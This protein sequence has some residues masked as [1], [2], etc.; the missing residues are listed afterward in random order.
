MRKIKKI[1]FVLLFVVL[2]SFNCSKIRAGDDESAS[3]NV[4]VSGIPSGIS[5]SCTSPTCANT[6]GLFGSLKYKGKDVPMTGLKIILMK[7]ENGKEK[8]I[9][10]GNFFFTEAMCADFSVLFNSA[11][12]TCPIDYCLKNN[13]GE[14]KTSRNYTMSGVFMDGDQV[15]SVD[16]GTITVNYND[17]IEN[18]VNNPSV[19]ENI[20]HIFHRI[21]NDISF[22]RFL[23]PDFDYYLVFEPILVLHISYQYSDG[24]SNYYHQ[25]Y[26]GTL[27]N[28]IL[29]ML[30]TNGNGRNGVIGFDAN[31]LKYDN[32]NIINSTNSDF[33]NPGKYFNGVD[34]INFSQF[35][36]T[37]S[38]DSTKEQ[39]ESYAKF[40]WEWIKSDKINSSCKDTGNCFNDKYFDY[41]ANFYRSLG[42]LSV[43]GNAG[44]YGSDTTWHVIDNFLVN[45]YIAE[46]K[47]DYVGLSDD[48]VEN[49]SAGLSNNKYFLRAIDATRNFSSYGKG[50]ITGSKI[51][52]NV[53]S[54]NVTIKKF[55]GTSGST[56]YNKKAKFR[57]VQIDGEYVS[58]LEK[59]ASASEV[60]FENVP[61]GKYKLVEI[62]DSGN[63]DSVGQ[64]IFKIVESGV[65]KNLGIVSNIDS[66]KAESNEFNVGVGDKT[67]KVYNSETAACTT[68][69][70]NIFSTYS[71]E[72]ARG[73]NLIDK[74]VNYYDRNDNYS[75]MINFQKNSDIMNK[76]SIS[77]TDA[78]TLCSKATTT[79]PG[80]SLKC[81]GTSSAY[82]DSEKNIISNDS[83]SYIASPSSLHIS[84]LDSNG[85]SAYCYL[86]LEQNFNFSNYKIFAG[87]IIWPDKIGTVSVIVHCDGYYNKST[88]NDKL[89]SSSVLGVIGDLIPAIDISWKTG[90]QNLNQVILTDLNKVIANGNEY[91][92]N[93]SSVMANPDVQSTDSSGFVHNKWEMKFEYILKYPNKCYGKGISGVLY[94]GDDLDTSSEE[95]LNTYRDVGYGLAIS[96]YESNGAKK[97]TLK[98]G[99]N[100]VDCPFSVSN[101]LDCDEECCAG[102]CHGGPGGKKTNI[103]NNFAFRVIDTS[104]PFPGYTGEG[105]YTGS[106]WCLSANI[107]KYR[108]D[109]SGNI[110]MVGDIND[111]KRITTDFD[112]NVSETVFKS[113]LAGDIDGDGYITYSNHCG[114]D[115]DTDYC[116]L[117]SYI[118]Y[119]VNAADGVELMKRICKPDNKFVDKYIINAPNSNSSDKPMYSFTITP[120]EIRNIRAYNKEHSYSDFNM[121]CTNG[122][123]CLSNFITNWIVKKKIVVSGKSSTISQLVTAANSSCYDDRFKLKWCNNK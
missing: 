10:A 35:S 7:T 64:V 20:F 91:S 32:L 23:S 116:I 110:Y 118:R 15:Y 105:R 114:S 72:A 56:K 9:T 95:F 39:A 37:L 93:F 29:G 62:I 77:D 101:M 34:K 57:L 104:N 73:Y 12:K 26:G 102:I 81:T 42:F 18:M 33:V 121:S 13:G 75:N 78:M 74:Y 70:K 4:N 21:N 90:G 45:P 28:I 84:D 14:C 1:F 46:T 17:I 31:Q 117:D 83:I 5:D 86:K 50:I 16:T 94:C 60:V 97:A 59:S 113:S 47:G 27:Q 92:T 88:M 119:N 44:N 107:G 106:N 38:K 51:R 36:K 52:K 8:R 43:V 2:L 48:D 54:S 115:S 67:I 98:V 89:K 40:Y 3:Y 109:D 103:L 122:E 58:T 11:S 96:E 108:K 53:Y 22:E 41:D 120:E 80:N 66:D 111:D 25:Y 112:F 71:T 99:T 68:V 55:L 30:Q 76:S 24:S 69:V 63:V 19:I 87:G 85:T 49:K 100:S 61:A 6:N 82:Y 79:P 123:H 65:D